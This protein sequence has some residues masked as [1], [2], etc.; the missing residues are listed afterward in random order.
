MALGL[1][2]TWL[3]SGCRPVVEPELVVWHAYRGEEAAGLQSLVSTWAEQTGV[4][5]EVVPIP[6]QAFANKLAS[7]IPRGNG[8]DLF[9]A[10]H[11]QAGSWARSGLIAGLQT[12]AQ[13][14]NASIPDA[15]ADACR[16]DGQDWC[17]PLSVKNI[18]LF[19]NP[20]LLAER[21]WEVATTVSEL[22]R[23][24][25]AF[26]DP[27]TGR[28]GLVYQ[29]ADFYFHAAW[30]FSFGAG[31]TDAEGRPS[32]ESDRMAASLTFVQQLAG[33]DGM[34]PRD[35]D[36]NV[37]RDRFASA[38]ALY[39]IN[40]PWFAGELGELEYRVAPLPVNDSTGLP[41]R[42]LLTVEAAF[43]SGH[44]DVARQS[45]AS[46]LALF[47]ASPE[48]A[49]RRAL[50]GGQVPAL[51]AGEVG[52]ILRD[53]PVLESFAA[54][55]EA[56]VAMSNDP[57]MRA[58][59]EPANRML[60]R[61]L[62][63]ESPAAAMAQA[64]RD[65][66][67]ALEPPPAAASATPYVALV[68]LLMVMAAVMWLRQARTS[69]MWTRMVEHRTAYAFIAPAVVASTVLLF[70]PFVVGAS[71]SLFAHEEGRFT[72]V[73]LSNFARI[74]LAADQ[75]VWEPRNFWYTLAVTVLWT[76]ANV[77]LHVTIG[78]WLAL[79]LRD[80]W[81]RMKG[82]Y[83][84][85][86]IIPWA[87]PNYITALVWKSLFNFNFGA[88]N[89][90]LGLM[91]VEPVDWFSRFSTSF[92]AN[93]VTNTWLGFPFMMVVSLGALQSI[94][95][96]LED[97]AE[98]DGASKWQRFRHVTLPLLAP[99]LVPA[100]ILGSVWT[101]NM[102]NVIYL[103]SGGGPD[104][105]TDILITEAYRWAFQRQEQYGY[106]AAYGCLIFG[107]LLLWN[108]LTERIQRGGR[109]S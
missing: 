51:G 108:A 75:A 23:Q 40:G 26:N 43:V 29:A 41:L 106:A 39:A 35:V 73:G 100:I 27:G 18:A 107:V 71:I 28:Y 85:L 77:F 98:V 92:T 89:Q 45:L 13:Q 12:D 47:L 38:N 97:A 87:V 14:W 46:E 33:P 48:A 19:Y 64:S 62:R 93:L 69:R 109:D 42:P 91:G 56:G 44:V 32:L 65:L 53:Q 96:D 16:F 83:R 84:A 63:G 103:V 86:L 72:F 31:L 70:V 76:G 90:I 50:E 102:F 66:E 17:V 59:W 57:R 4:V 9:L 49:R 37:V 20:A 95:R 2:A 81:V 88:I 94:P 36:Y 58:L 82:V 61:V 7:A 67:L 24:V 6:Y 104:S 60:G 8:P 105:R 5:V 79:L 78:L 15:Y 21:G 80:P 99:A 25:E 34:L 30:L 10:A 74:L 68:S 54:A 11:E 1:L 52:A 3:I 22:L 55:A 101:F